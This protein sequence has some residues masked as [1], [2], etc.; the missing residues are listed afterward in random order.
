VKQALE[1]RQ[2]P[3][4]SE[5]VRGEL[6]AIHASTCGEDRRPEC[7][8]DLALHLPASGKQAA[9]DA[10]GIDVNDARVAL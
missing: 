6:V 8:A 7:A 4:I 9:H 2:A 10:I 1:A 3:L 5:D